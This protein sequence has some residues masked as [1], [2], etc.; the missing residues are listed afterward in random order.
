MAGLLRACLGGGGY[1]RVTA[2]LVALH[3]T[4]PYAVWCEA[5]AP[6][7]AREPTNRYR[8][9]LAERGKA[10]EIR[11]LGIRHPGLAPPPFPT[12]ETGFRLALD[13]MAAGVPALAG[14]PLL[15]LPE[16]LA[17]RLW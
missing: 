4:S 11:I 5:F 7:D 14:L 10:H 3:A 6:P 17:G 9:L 12:E 13:Q 8:F 15:Y 1:P 2:S 16:G